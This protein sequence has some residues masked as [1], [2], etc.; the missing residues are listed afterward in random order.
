[1]A[2]NLDDVGSVEGRTAYSFVEC[3]EVLRREAV[4][5]IAGFEGL[6]E[7]E[8]CYS[9]DHMIFVQNGVPTIAFTTEQMAELMRTVTHTE[10]DTPDLIDC[11]KLVDLAHALVELVSQAAQ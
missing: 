10:R 2:L 1:M 3:P 4:R 6:T 8:P 9:G 11:H 5:A 7:G